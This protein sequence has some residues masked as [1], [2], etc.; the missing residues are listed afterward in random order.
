MYI[1]H[2][3]VHSSA[4]TAA[5][6]WRRTEDDHWIRADVAT[7]LGPPP[8]EP[9]D[10]EPAE[11]RRIDWKLPLLACPCAGVYITYQSTFGGNQTLTRGLRSGAA[12]DHT[13]AYLHTITYC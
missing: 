1:P 8:D 10:E 7:F 3:P 9:E 12:Y 6:G 2:E 4:R 11:H 5:I 13:Y